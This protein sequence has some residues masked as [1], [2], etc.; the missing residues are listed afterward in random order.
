MVLYQEV[1]IRL[2]V[3]MLSQNNGIILTIVN[4]RKLKRNKYNQ[5]QL[6]YF[7]IEED[8]ILG[9]IRIIKNQNENFL[10]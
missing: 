8:K 3:K 6:M 5:V 9:I 1:T 2:F 10:K 4:V 7:F